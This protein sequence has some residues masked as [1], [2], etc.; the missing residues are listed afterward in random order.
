MKRCSWTRSDKIYINYHDNE[1]GTPVYD[2][3]DLFAKL[4]LD[5][6]QAGLSWLTILKKRQ[7]FYKAFDGF[8]PELI[9]SYNQ[10]KIDL[11]LNNKGIVRNRLK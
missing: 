8:D 10:K 3:K 2:S 4:I 7:N 1:W 11:L 6:F 5:G 9:A